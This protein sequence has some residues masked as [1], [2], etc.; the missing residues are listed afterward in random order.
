MKKFV[1]YFSILVLTICLMKMWRKIDTKNKN[2]D[3]KIGKIN[4]IFEFFIPKVGYMTFYMKIWEEKIWPIF[5][6]FFTYRSKNENLNEN[7][8]RKWVRSLNSPYQNYTEI[9]MKIY[10][11]KVFKPLFRIFLI[12][13]GK[14]EY[15]EV[16]TS[17]NNFNFWIFHI[18]IRLCASFHES[19]KKNI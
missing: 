19:L 16:K 14:Y 15:E 6:T 11:K 4:L 5:K 8:L 13:R 9:F 7:S 17:K 2:K 12:S 3:E 10:G 1:N 18:K